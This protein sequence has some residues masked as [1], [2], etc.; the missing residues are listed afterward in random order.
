MQT[1]AS[2]YFASMIESYDSLIRRAVPRYDEM[3]ERLVAYLPERA[4]RILELGCG[5][6]NFSLALARRYPDA[7]IAFI[8]AAPE[9]LD[10]T[11]RRLEEFA[12]DSAARFRFLPV[13]FEEIDPA[14]GAFDLIV[15]TISL[16][17]VRDKKPLYVRIAALL[18]DVGT[19]RFSDQLRGGTEEN[20]RI[21]WEAWLAF[22]RQPGHCSPDEIE[23]LLQHAEAHDHYTPLG[24]H[25]RLLENAGFR[26]VDCVWRN[27]I[28]GIVT[29]EK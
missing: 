28:W 27:W 7:D 16:H 26:H 10:A 9:M 24:E 22:C 2:E 12:P 15:S 20:H 3:L 23:S 11:R 13:R 29:A 18:R 6:G 19:F 21:N 25:V 14:L 8:D 17:H 4:E 5:T 1:T